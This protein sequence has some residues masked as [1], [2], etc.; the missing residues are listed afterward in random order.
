MVLSQYPA[1]GTGKCG[2]TDVI[3][4]LFLQFKEH[5]VEKSE[6]ENEL[7]QVL[8]HRDMRLAQVLKAEQ[9]WSLEVKD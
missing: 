8:W 7:V 4:L 9:P 1:V 3:V 6:T 5:I 2:K